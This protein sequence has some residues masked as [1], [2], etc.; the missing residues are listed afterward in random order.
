MLKKI[1]EEKTFKDDI[2]KKGIQEALDN[3]N[4]TGGKTQKELE[5]QWLD[6]LIQRKREEVE[7]GGENLDMIDDSE[8]YSASVAESKNTKFTEEAKAYQTV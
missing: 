3:I 5:E 6:E 2:N 4:T 8:Y 7:R 1:R